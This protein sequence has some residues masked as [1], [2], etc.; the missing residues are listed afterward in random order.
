MY[1]SDSPVLLADSVYWLGSTDT[2]NF[3]Q[4][5]VY[6]I[7]RNGKALL[8]DPGPKDIFPQIRRALESI[9]PLEELSG[10]VLSN[11][12]PD[13]CSSIS[14]WEESGFRGNIIVHWK[15]GVF[16][17]AYK[18]KNPLYSVKEVQSAPQNLPE[19]INFLPF[20]LGHGTFLATYD[21]ISGALFSSVFFRGLRAFGKAVCG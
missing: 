12:N 7:Y 1:K 10:I 13:V 6:L 21:P 15:N 9:L 20:S 5:N 4:I 8:I 2:S 19:E 3:L 18:L 16:I 17:N 14:L 11:Q